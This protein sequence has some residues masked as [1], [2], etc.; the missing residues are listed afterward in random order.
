MSD[1]FL[2]RSQPARAFYQALSGQSVRTFESLRDAIALVD[3]GITDEQ[4]RI[5]DSNGSG[6]IDYQAKVAHRLADFVR[7]R[8]AALSAQ[9]GDNT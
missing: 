1:P 6:H 7:E 3:V 8:E 4:F 9:T 2:P 5:A